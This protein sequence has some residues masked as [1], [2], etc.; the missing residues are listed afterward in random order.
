MKIDN[1]S[2]L[3]FKSINELLYSEGLTENQT[4]EFKRE[5]SSKD[6]KPN[7]LEFAKDITAFTNASGGIVF[8]GIDEKVM[9]IH[10]TSPMIGNQKIEDWIANVLNDLVD[11]T[12][13][14]SIHQ[15]PISEDEKLQVIVVEVLEG[16]DKPYYV[17]VDKKPIPYIRKGTSIFPAKPIDIKQ[18][19]QSNKMDAIEPIVIK[20]KAKGR[21]IQQ[22]GQNYGK[23][24]N[25]NRV[26]NVTE[27]QYNPSS[28][29]TDQQAKQIKDKVDEIVEI[30]DKANKFKT[31]DSKSK[32][33]AQTWIGI[34]NRYNITKYTLLP[35][36][37]FDDCMKWLQKEIAYKHVNKL[38]KS[39]NTSWKNKRYGSIYAKAQNNFGM[40]KED[41]YQYAYDN[42][43]LKKPIISLKDLSDVNLNKLYKALFS[44]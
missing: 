38:R 25:T 37:Q 15:I 44:K 41:L 1:I 5:L 16:K 23:V 29:I 36:S 33:Y 20:Q 4:I 18:M 9:E 34:R 22:I 28:H 31:T 10:G 3:S 30:N 6:G 19:Y 27:V 42:L 43:N 8:I 13:E 11:K 32:F 39:D 24:I 12:I 26:Q 40:S 21:N 2:K 17:M 7:S 14:Y 35:K